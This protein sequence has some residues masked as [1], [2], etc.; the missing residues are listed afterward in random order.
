M[1]TTTRLPNL[2]YNSRMI[3]DKLLIYAACSPNA[4]SR[5]KGPWKKF[6][7]FQDTNTVRISRW[8]VDCFFRNN[9]LRFFKYTLCVLIY[10]LSIYQTNF[11]STLGYYFLLMES[12]PLVLII[13]PV[14]RIFVWGMVLNKKW[15]CLYFSCCRQVQG[16]APDFLF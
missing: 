6:A 1:A 4:N 9:V 14:A 15:I 13:R 12:S 3:M 8:V 10:K 11:S 7:L 16:H 2:H 5:T